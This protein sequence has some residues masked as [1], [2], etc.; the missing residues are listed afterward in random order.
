MQTFL[1]DIEFKQSARNLDRARLGSQ[2][3]ES[4]H[5]LASLLKVND[6]LVTPKRDVSNH[7]ASQLWVGYERELG[8]YIY[9]HI[10]EWI[11]RGYK[12]DINLRNFHMVTKGM[13]RGIY[14]RPMW[15]TKEVIETHRN[16]LYRKK[17]DYYPQSWCGDREMRYDWENYRESYKNTKVS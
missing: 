11:N 5:I 7:P 12:C 1:T 8:A 9:T 15:I 3:Y 14:V 13:E 17:P 6:K 10:E 16:C 2:I 4:I